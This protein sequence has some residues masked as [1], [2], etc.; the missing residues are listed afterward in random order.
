MVD[1]RGR[2]VYSQRASVLPDGD[3]VAGCDQGDEADH[4]Q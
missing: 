4:A 3:V 2:F 1:L